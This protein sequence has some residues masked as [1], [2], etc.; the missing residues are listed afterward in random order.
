MSSS[1]LQR[2]QAARE[3]APVESPLDKPASILDRQIEDREHLV[4]AVQ[5]ATPAT[6][7]STGGPG[8]HAE[9]LPATPVT[10]P[11]DAVG[12]AKDE[13]ADTNVVAAVRPA[14]PASSDASGL[15]ANPTNPGKVDPAASADDQADA[16][17]HTVPAVRSVT[18]QHAQEDLDPEAA[19]VQPASVILPTPDHARETEAAYRAVEES[20]LGHAADEADHVVGS[21]EALR[22]QIEAANESEGLDAESAYFAAFAVESLLK[23]C[24]MQDPSVTASFESAV[25]VPE[26]KTKV[27]TEALDAA[28][29]AANSIGA[30]IKASFIRALN[31]VWIRTRHLGS[32]LDSLVTDAR[33]VRGNGTKPTIEVASKLI[34]EGDKPSTDLKASFS[35]AA[36]ILKYMVKDF[37]KQANADF[38]A[39]MD[40]MWKE[41]H[42]HFAKDSNGLSKADFGSFSSDDIKKALERVAADWKDPRVKLGGDPAAP[43]VGG[44]QLFAKIEES[45]RM[46]GLDPYKGNDPVVKKFLSLAYDAYPT[47]A[48]STH[49]SGDADTRTK[50]EVAAL[51]PE[52]IIQIAN[53][54]RD[55][56]DNFGAWRAFVE[57]LSGITSLAALFGP[58]AALMSGPFML[59][60]Y[61]VWV[62]ILFGKAIA[63][64]K[65]H[66]D[67]PL[68]EIKAMHAAQETSNRMRLHVGYDAGLVL[69]RIGHT[70]INLAKQSLN[71]YAHASAEAFDQQSSIDGQ[72]VHETAP[73]EPV[74]TPG[75]QNLAPQGEVMPHQNSWEDQPA[76]FQTIEDDAEIAASIESIQDRLVE[77]DVLS[78]HYSLEA[79]GDEGKKEAWHR[80]AGRAIAEAY[81]AVVDFFKRLYARV[82]HWLKRRHQ[83]LKAA[84]E[85]LHRGKASFELDIPG[86]VLAYT[87]DFLKIPNFSGFETFLK[88]SRD[89]ADAVQDIAELSTKLVKHDANKLAE[90]VK[91]ANPE[92][93]GGEKETAM[94]KLYF[95][96]GIP[97]AQVTAAR[98]KAGMAGYKVGMA[99]SLPAK[100]LPGAFSVELSYSESGTPMLKATDIEAPKQRGD[101]RI[102]V[103][104]AEL[105]HYGESVMETIT[106]L[107]FLIEQQE[108]AL[109]RTTRTTDA[110][111][112]PGSEILREALRI[113]A[114]FGSLAARAMTI[115]N[116]WAAAAEQIIVIA[117]RSAASRQKP[118]AESR[119]DNLP[120]WYKPISE[121]SAS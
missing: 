18:P 74:Q 93:L 61:L 47:V 68:V 102:K 71:A 115:A 70:F 36:E 26:G 88:S 56:V 59:Q 87:G 15:P 8:L 89:L 20:S 62:G 85:R 2:F 73:N 104:Q 30:R 110:L 39:N 82:V 25:T 100:D 7:D 80:R 72:S 81:R 95:A 17:K 43:L 120:Y 66:S 99:G 116:R 112:G 52:E 60:A 27:S 45:D 114:D 28:L 48:G 54:F 90:R 4:A 46:F 24:G 121:L 111:D 58:A 5:S 105:I 67:M 101:G 6:H 98:V 3:S 1:L 35:K 86:D 65:V 55:A 79:E 94:R 19:Q 21:I 77:I 23:R 113:W 49:S 16:E 63:R 12:V 76:S 108:K 57:K 64:V 31:P 119:G 109:D 33:G 96:L 53:G 107:D 41:I 118:A 37:G 103:S 14:K 42:Q 34:A 40:V 22:G 75:S 69:L 78:Q 13:R 117:D 10:K 97:N 92:L 11:V 32:A 91:S 29:E 38:I 83:S 9:G 106:R 50:V 44:Y 84:L 51:S